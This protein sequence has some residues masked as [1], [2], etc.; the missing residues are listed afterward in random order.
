MLK[1]RD[2]KYHPP[3]GKPSD[4]SKEG[5]GLRP[6]V[7]GAAGDAGGGASDV[8]GASGVDDGGARDERRIVRDGRRM[9]EVRPGA[10][11]TLFAELARY[12]ADVCVSIYRGTHDRGMEVND[13]VDRI[14]L[15]DALRQARRKIE[16]MKIEGVMDD[17]LDPALA[18]LDDEFFL[19]NQSPGMALF[20]AP[21]YHARVALPYD[22]GN[23]I[24]VHTSFVLVPLTPM[25]NEGDDYFLLKLSK[26]RPVLFRGDRYGLE[27]LEIPEMPLGIEDVVHL[28]EK[29]GS[30]VSRSGAGK[31]EEKKNIELYLRDVDRTL[32]ERLLGKEHKP[33]LLA[34]VDY[35]LSI[36]RDVN[37]YPYL[38]KEEL[39]GS[40]DHTPL[41]E[42]AGEAR[43]KMNAYF[44]EQRR[45]EV[46]Q[47]LDHGTAPVTTFPR[48][49]IR[50]TFEGRVAQLFLARGVLLWGRYT[51]S[52]VEPVIRDEEEP[53]DDCLTN[54]AVVQT[55]LHGGQVYLA[56][57]DKMPVAG[58]MAAV[59]RYS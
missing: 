31:T 21:D 45:K 2:R 52:Q 23:E 37:S 24:Y 20:L 16:E 55:V 30:G 40:Y 57:R 3:K 50:A 1:D 33:L 28:E 47:H 10:V 27:P 53:G 8:G 12:P 18:L 58:E 6:D 25:M 5:L 41:P 4:T 7:R 19:P 15:K 39:T 14:G 42:L 13:R 22:P 46:R 44:E 11:R 43:E 59:L 48:D 38:L 29:G 36:Y 51:A 56:D 34:G 17:I 54:Q 26:R 49:V 9:V 32:R 35:I